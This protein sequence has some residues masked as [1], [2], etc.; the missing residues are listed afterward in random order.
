MKSV[1]IYYSQTGNTEKVAQA[2]QG[3]IQ[4]VA[5][6]CDIAKVKEAEVNNLVEYDLIGIGA[7]V[8][9]FREPGNVA[10]FLKRMGPLS[11]KN[12][13]IFDTHGGHPGNIQPRAWRGN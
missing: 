10:I 1:V 8:F 7:P 12:C 13:F 11:G 2:I 4:S 9:G 6:Q 5:G 3:G